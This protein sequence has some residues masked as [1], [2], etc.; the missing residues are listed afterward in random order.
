MSNSES[1]FDYIESEADLPL[2]AIQFSNAIKTINQ[3]KPKGKQIYIY[4]PVITYD[5]FTVSEIKDVSSPSAVL[6]LFRSQILGPIEKVACLFLNSRNDIVE[7]FIFSVMSNG[8]VDQSA[9]YPREVI[10]MAILNNSSRIII[11]HNH[12]SNHAGPSTADHA[13][14]KVMKESAKLLGI[15][16]LDHIIITEDSYYSFQEQNCL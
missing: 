1:L 12:P 10:K 6:E 8:T 14:S 11:C 7:R 3:I 5:R 9:F 15:E 13:I 16:L 4:R 2:E